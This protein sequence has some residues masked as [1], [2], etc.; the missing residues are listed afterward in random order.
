MLVT[1]PCVSVLECCKLH[2]P[3]AKAQLEADLDAVAEQARSED[4][5]ARE[6]IALGE[7]VERTMLQKFQA[8]TLA[9]LSHYLEADEGQ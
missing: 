2:E 3:E 8:A 4:R 1:G 6:R 9:S 7:V 5:T